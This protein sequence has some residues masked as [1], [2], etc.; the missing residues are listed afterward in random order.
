MNTK[1]VTYVDAIIFVIL[2][3]GMSLMMALL[4]AG[5]V[6]SFK[7]WKLVAV[8][9]N[10]KN[11]NNSNKEKQQVSG[12]TRLVS[13][14]GQ[15][16]DAEGKIKSKSKSKSQTVARI[17]LFSNWGELLNKKA[18]TCELVEFGKIIAIDKQSMTVLYGARQE[19]VIPTYYIREYDQENVI[20]DISARYL[21]HYKPQE[22]LQEP[23]IQK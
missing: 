18:K 6:L 21:Y 14:L 2:M 17:R 4:F 22:K 12:N 13:N 23:Y 19:Y 3:V 20:I 10:P 15:A 9:R 7:W 16:T 1:L 8:P 11:R 5:T